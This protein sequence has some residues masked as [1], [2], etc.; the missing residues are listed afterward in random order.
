MACAAA[1]APAAGAKLTL[2]HDTFSTV[3]RSPGGATQHGESSSGLGLAVTRMLVE[4]HGGTITLASRQGR[5][6]TAT[7]RVPAVQ[8]FADP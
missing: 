2:L 5:G 3:Y 1:F 4:A 8:T 7:L 6:T